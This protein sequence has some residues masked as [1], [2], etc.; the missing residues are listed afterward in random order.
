MLKED[1][2]L[3]F[4]NIATIVISSYFLANIKDKNL[5]RVFPKH[6]RLTLFDKAILILYILSI[7]TIFVSEII[8]FINN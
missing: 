6:A 1:L 4:G 8:P 3:L 7:L 2:D 5:L